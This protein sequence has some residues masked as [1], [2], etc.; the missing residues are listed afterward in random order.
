MRALLELRSD[1]AVLTFG[2][3]VLTDRVPS[4]NSRNASSTV[5]GPP[6]LVDALCVSAATRRPLLLTGVPGVGKTA[7]AAAMTNF[8]ASNLAQAQVD[9]RT[10]IV[11]SA[12]L[13]FST[14]TDRDALL[15]GVDHIARLAAAQSNVV[16]ELGS[17]FRPG[18]FGAAF[19]PSPTSATELASRKGE[20]SEPIADVVVLLL[21][22][23]DKAD[24]S[25][26][27]DL[28]DAIDRGEFRDD[29]G[30]RHEADA[31]VFTVIT[32]NDER[33]LPDA[34]MRRCIPFRLVVPGRAGLVA[35]GLAAFANDQRLKR[36]NPLSPEQIGL[37]A[38]LF[39][40]PENDAPG[41][42]SPGTAEF[43]DLLATVAQLE[44]GDDIDRIR[45]LAPLVWVKHPAR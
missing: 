15:G 40:P 2:E 4:G 35:I 23:I 32:S 17:F 31:A 29:L 3:L 6:T 13:T 5:V 42:R 25:L 43:I 7:V 24:S 20:R 14:R 21:D 36:L 12:S 38:D 19:R 37:L 10:R 18:V 1:P 22:E 8:L 44:L 45:D 26:P 16:D 30:R 34:F 28:L 33:D 11:K 27:N 39:T 41:S 9:G